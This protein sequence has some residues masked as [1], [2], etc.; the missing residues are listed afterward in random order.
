MATAGA[1][2]IEQWDR[3]WSYGSLHS[4]SQV[5]GGNYQGAIAGFWRACFRDLEA[6]ARVVD[7]ATGNGAVALLALEA[8]E[9]AGIEVEVSGIDLAKIDPLHQVQDSSLRARLQCIRFYPRTPAEALPFADGAMDLACSQFG[10]EYSDLAAAVGE[11]ARVCR[12]GAR[13]ALM[14]HHERSQLLRATA[15]EIAQLDFVLDEVRLYV[16]AR[17]LL[18]AM[19]ERGTAG[20]ARAGSKVDRK[21]RA[22][23]DALQKIQRE[24]RGRDQPRMLLGP[25]NYIREIFAGVG[26]APYAQLLDLLEETRQRVLANRQRLQD[27]Q[28]AALG[29]Q[30]MDALMKRFVRVGFDVTGHDVLHEHDGVLLG[31]TLTATRQ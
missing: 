28:R 25:T 7:I 20:S 27:M 4:F 1:C 21:R 3:Y 22:L 9:A 13:V 5:M 31:W 19:A 14:L 10:L 12:S 16:H 26:R 2:G 15:D 18:R 17:N 29:E 6:G 11:L 24:A 23:D 30:E 8:A